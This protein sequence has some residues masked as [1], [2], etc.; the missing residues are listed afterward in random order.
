MISTFRKVLE[1][2]FALKQKHKDEQ[3]YLMQGLVKLIMRI[4]YGV[5]IRKDIKESSIVNQ[6]NG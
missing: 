2:I 3:N 1:K 6:N 5:Q 4:L